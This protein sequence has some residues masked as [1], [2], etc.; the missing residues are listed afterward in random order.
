Y[1]RHRALVRAAPLIRAKGKLERR[2]GTTNVLVSELA[3]LERKA[4]A[5]A[6]DAPSAGQAPSKVPMR[7]RAVA[8]LRAVAPTG[9]SFGRL[10]R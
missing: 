7:E 2:E 9:H 3:D 5:P 1:E 8:Q 10:A 4:S 6:V